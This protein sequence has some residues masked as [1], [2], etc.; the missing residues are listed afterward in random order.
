LQKQK[1]AVSSRHEPRKSDQQTTCDSLSE[2][3]AVTGLEEVND[4]TLADFR[5]EKQQELEELFTQVLAALRQEG[6]ITLKQVMQDGTKSKAQAG[7]SSYQQEQTIREHRERAGRRVAEMGDPGNEQSN[8]GTKQAREPGRR[9]QQER[10]ENALQELQKLQ[11]RK[12]GEKAKSKVRVSSS[13]RHAPVMQQSDGGLALSYNAQISADAAHGLMVGVVTAAA[14]GSYG[15]WKIPPCVRFGKR[16][17]VSKRRSNIARAAES[18]NFATPGSKASWG[19]GR[20]T[21]AACAMWEPNFCGPASPTTCHRGCAGV[22]RCPCPPRPRFRKPQGEEKTES[23]ATAQLKKTK[24]FSR[25]K[26]QPARD[27]SSQLLFEGWGLAFPPPTKHLAIEFAV[28]AST[29]SIQT[30]ATIVCRCSC[31]PLALNL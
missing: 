1:S 11:D 24:S 22:N 31:S 25:R 17:P 15:T 3:T 29:S 28:A 12:H 27:V 13:D 18:W 5:V 30:S 21:C 2:P 20:F 26:N 14:V 9:E 16:W 10:L 8:S 23:T 6:L 4:H 7:I 19:C